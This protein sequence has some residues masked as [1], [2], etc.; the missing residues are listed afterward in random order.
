MIERG[1]VITD[2]RGH[3]R[4]RHI[5]SFARNLTA[6]DAAAYMRETDRYLLRF[7]G[8]QSPLCGRYVFVIS[9]AG[10]F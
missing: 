3:G 8:K 2:W 5:G 1:L 10:L 9:F 7:E 6:C 4:R